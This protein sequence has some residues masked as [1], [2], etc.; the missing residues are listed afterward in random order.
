MPSR[1]PSPAHPFEEVTTVDD[2]GARESRKEEHGR[3]GD[4]G[5]RDG[6]PGGEGLVDRNLAL[7]G[8]GVAALLTF[9]AMYALGSVGSVEARILLESTLPSIRFLYSTL[10]TASATILALMLT[11]LGLSEATERR[12]KHV[13]YRRVQQISWMAAVALLLSVGLLMVLIFPLEE[14]EGFPSGWFNIVYYVILGFSAVLGGLMFSLVAMLMNAIRHLVRVV[15]PGVEAPIAM[16]E[17][18]DEV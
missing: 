9:V 10:G 11:L 16:D 8:G 3:E 6:D 4:G 18:D 17:E 15:R 2:N 13:H 1:M 7:A 14:A 12:L 5:G